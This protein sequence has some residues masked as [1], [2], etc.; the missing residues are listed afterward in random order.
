MLFYGIFQIYL[1][2]YVYGFVYFFQL[3]QLF[4]IVIIFG[5]IN[6]FRLFQ[7][8]QKKNQLVLVKIHRNVFFLLL[9]FYFLVLFDWMWFILYCFYIGLFLYFP[10]HYIL[11]E[12]YPIVT[13]IIILI[14][15]VRFL[16]K[17]HAFVRENV[18]KTILFGQIYSQEGLIFLI[19][20]CSHINTFS[21]FFFAVKTEDKLND[22]SDSQQLF[23]IPHTPC[24]E[25]S[26]FLYFI[27]APT[28]IY[29]DTYPRSSSVRWKY[30]LTQ[31]SQFIAAA[32]F[33]YYLF[34]R[35]CLP[36]FRHFKSEHVTVKIFVL[37][38]LNCTLPGAL[39]LFCGRIEKDKNSSFLFEYEYLAFYG[40]LH[41]WLNAFAEMLRFADR[42][43]YSVKDSLN[44]FELE[45]WEF[46][47]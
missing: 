3:V 47:F 40:F 5:H 41:C 12:N 26:K 10:V 13:R 25:F 22:S 8:V 44:E 27:F 7:L 36:V 11:E 17:S 28:L 1:L 23:S 6:V 16:M 43:F 20:L 37:S 35:F 46:Y 9:I 38:I 4:I 33:S 18:P 21:F 39:L 45:K 42:Q 2:V 30:V 15:Q 19:L 24:P 34:Y 29:R 31:L 14:E 32:L